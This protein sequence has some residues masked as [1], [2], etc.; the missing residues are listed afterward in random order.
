MSDDD[1]IH[2][3]ETIPPPA[4]ESDAYNAPTKVGPM[5]A[6]IVEEMMHA[7]ERKAADLSKLAEQKKAEKA[8]REQRAVEAKARAVIENTP[9][10]AATPTRSN[11]PKPVQ[12]LPSPAP[13]PRM[14][15]DEEEDDDDAETLLSKAAKP[16]ILPPLPPAARS[17]P[18]LPPHATPLQSAPRIN[19]APVAPVPAPP[20]APVP[21]PPIALEPPTPI[22]SEPPPLP[23]TSRTM[24]N[25]TPNSPTPLSPV[26]TVPPDAHARTAVQYPGIGQAS[27]WWAVGAGL[28]I[29]L[30]GLALYLFVR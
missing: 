1:K 11:R 29:F 6:A 14:Y 30:V 23:L 24:P 4:G 2:K 18:A 17:A 13:P 5:A 26:L 10:K 20:I 7:A 19:P 28:L 16:P 22:A 15:E 9:P 12:A 8:V 27:V 21:A 25:P 3:V